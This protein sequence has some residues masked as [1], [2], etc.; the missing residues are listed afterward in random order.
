M[1]ILR[2]SDRVAT[3]WKNGGGLTREVAVW[4]PGAG[5]DD[6]HWRI[7]VAE[8]DRDATF[9]VFADVDRHLTVLQGQLYLSLDGGR[10]V[11]RAAKFA[12]LA[13][14]GEVPVVGCVK[15]GPVRDLNVMTRRRCVSATVKRMR[16][17]GDLQLPSSPFARVLFARCS[18]QMSEPI[19]NRLDPNDA[20]LINPNTP[21]VVASAARGTVF[22]ITF[23][24]AASPP[25]QAA[26]TQ[27]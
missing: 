20:L 10:E 9:S 24:P 8:F 11:R 27:A 18:L 15:A 1:Q 16:M 3:L 14:A 26:E 21:P 17:T 25:P 19:A 12:S 23:E 13:F 4:P 22:L 6:F 5:Y 7:S 2:A